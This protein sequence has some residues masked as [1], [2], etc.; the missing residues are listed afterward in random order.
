M[1]VTRASCAILIEHYEKKKDLAAKKFYENNKWRKIG[2]DYKKGLVK[3]K[4]PAALMMEHSEA[5]Q[6]MLGARIGYAWS[7]GDASKLFN[8]KFGAELGVEIAG[9]FLATVP[10]GVFIKSLFSGLITGGFEKDS[11]NEVLEQ[12]AA[13]KRHI[14]KKFEIRNI[15]EKTN[16]ELSKIRAEFDKLKILDDATFKDFVNDRLEYRI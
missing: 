11:P 6:G 10:G 16:T 8:W 4:S 7:K 2:D 1:D 9:V 14:D 3:W 12:I 13:L 5:I 15:E